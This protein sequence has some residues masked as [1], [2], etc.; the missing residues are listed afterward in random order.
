MSYT[1][2]ESFVK[3]VAVRFHLTSVCVHTSNLDWIRTPRHVDS[4]EFDVDVVQTAFTGHEV[5]S[6]TIYD[7]TCTQTNTVRLVR[8]H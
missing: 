6:V 1:T 4:V 3:S 5:H 7:I 2:V 8:F